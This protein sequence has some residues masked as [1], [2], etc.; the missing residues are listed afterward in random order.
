MN[1]LLEAT[2]VVDERGLTRK[3][4]ENQILVLP[5]IRIADRA[6]ISGA[7]RDVWNGLAGTEHQAF[8]VN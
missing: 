7:K 8:K 3:Q 4:D 1:A 6:A 5:Q 2:G